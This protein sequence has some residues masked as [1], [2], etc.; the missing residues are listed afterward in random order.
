[1]NV[2]VLFILLLV[3]VLLAFSPRFRRIGLTSCALLVALLLW[4]NIREAQ[5]PD[6]PDQTSSTQS[7]SRSTSAPNQ[8]HAKII[9]M[10]LDGRGAPWHLMGSV[11]N[12]SDLSI[13]WVRLNIERY[14]CPT[15]LAALTDC[16]LLWQGEHIARL[17]IAAG[18]TDKI[19]ESFYSHVAVPLQ[20]GM[21][22]DRITLVDTG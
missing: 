14:D 4:I 2:R 5:Q 7:N 10:Q 6:E 15:D 13:Q 12:V 19:D 9:V 21:L 11:Q 17:P 3:S 18:A 20:K 8:P 1:M 16:S 22:R